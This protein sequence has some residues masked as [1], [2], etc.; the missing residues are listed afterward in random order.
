MSC[1]LTGFLFA[2]GSLLADRHR[3]LQPGRI[4]LGDQ[5]PSAV[6]GVREEW[7]SRL[8]QGPSHCCRVTPELA[9]ERFEP[10][11]SGFR[12]ADT[13]TN[14]NGCPPSGWCRVRRA[15]VIVAS[16]VVVSLCRPNWSTGRPI[17]QFY[18]NVG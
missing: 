16:P 6:A 8:A 1:P 10:N 11:E 13:L 5:S 17:A 18:T 2:L 4:L 9:G 7:T 12:H 15:A 14:E 3:P